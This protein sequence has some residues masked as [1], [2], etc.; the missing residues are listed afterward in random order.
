MRP[1]GRFSRNKLF[2]YHGVS[3]G[4]GVTAIPFTDGPGRQ[5]VHGIPTSLY[6]LGKRRSY[7]FVLT[8][9]LIFSWVCAGFF[10]IFTVYD[11]HHPPVNRI[12]EEMIRFFSRSK[13][14]LGMSFNSEGLRG[15]YSQLVIAPQ[16]RGCP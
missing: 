4:F 2:S 14:L 6:A 5:F 12:A 10:G 11:A 7:D 13:N 15:I 1:A 9:N 16:L 3:E 8:R